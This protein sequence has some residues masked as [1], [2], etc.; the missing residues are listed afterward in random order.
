VFAAILQA[1]DNGA[2]CDEIELLLNQPHQTVSARIYDLV[3]EGRIHNTGHSRIT[4][5]G[6]AAIVYAIGSSPIN[7]TPAPS[8]SGIVY[9][10]QVKEFV[11][12]GFSMNNVS[13][14]MKDLQ[15]GCPFEMNL[16][17]TIP[18]TEA[19]ENML[20]V[21]FAHL[22]QRGE[23]FFASAELMDAI[24]VYLGDSGVREDRVEAA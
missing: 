19:T 12:I 7:P 4:R 1:G 17:G 20:H 15:C 11:K 18:G 9:F 14:R 21:R 22:R 13:I 3:R 24:K 23:W 8:Q 5:A 2:T 10:I 16:L 6:A